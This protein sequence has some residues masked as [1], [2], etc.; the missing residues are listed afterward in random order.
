MI[1]EN[2]V[3][4]SGGQRQR[5]GLARSLFL[6]PDLII[7]DEANSALDSATEKEIMED[8]LSL[9]SKTILFSTHKSR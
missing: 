3:R 9:S 7:L 8:I 4:L 5:I 6:N 2:G 1:G